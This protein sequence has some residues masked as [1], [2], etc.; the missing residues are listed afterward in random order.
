MV[1][2]STTRL[3]QRG[4]AARLRH[5]DEALCAGALTFEQAVQKRDHLGGL[6][7][8]GFELVCVAHR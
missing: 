1:A 8:I 2:K 5:V 6:Q 4:V 3:L 7:R